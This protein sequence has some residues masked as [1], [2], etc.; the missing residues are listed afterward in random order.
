[1]RYWI[2]LPPYHSL[3]GRTHPSPSF[4]SLPR[5]TLESAAMLPR[6]M[7]NRS[8]IGVLY[9]KEESYMLTRSPIC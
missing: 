1:M 8:P 7:V 5:P 2:L 4:T 6:R 3:P 9:A